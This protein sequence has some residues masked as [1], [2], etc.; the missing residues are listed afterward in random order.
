M[1]LADLIEDGSSGTEC[2]FGADGVSGTV[3]QLGEQQM[4]PADRTMEV[5]DRA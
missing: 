5:R 3:S 2:G 1:P 4:V